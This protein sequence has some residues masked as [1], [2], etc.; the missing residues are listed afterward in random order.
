MIP[1][2]YKVKLPKFLSY[3]IGVELLT[4][5]SGCP[6]L[7]AGVRLRHAVARVPGP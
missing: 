1:T 7:S 3:P 6:V 2:S 5:Q 4:A